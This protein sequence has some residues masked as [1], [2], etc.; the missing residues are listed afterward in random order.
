MTPPEFRIS[1]RHYSIILKQAQDN[2][3][4]ESG[5]FLGGKDFLIQAILPVFNQHLFNKTNTYSIT[6]EDIER[7]HRFFAKH[8]LDYYGV[9]H[10]HPKGIPYPSHQDISTGHKYHFIVGLQNPENPI[11][12][13]YEIKGLTP[14]QVP[15]VVISDKA[16]SILD[17]HQPTQE[18]IDAQ[19][20]F[21]PKTQV[22]RDPK[23][24]ALR[25]DQMLDN[26]KKE[27]PSYEKQDPLLRGSDFSTLA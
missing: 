6:G 24:E 14:V 4:Q 5:G 15:L 7:A 27:K 16:F 19:A 11:F 25:L 23:S 10:T 9:Y 20:A 8:Q 17:I 12:C 13:A 2:L 22:K 21:I 1:N 26:I 18:K 3:P